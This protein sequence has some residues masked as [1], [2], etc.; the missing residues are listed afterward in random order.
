MNKTNAWKLAL[1]TAVAV[2]AT[3]VARADTIKIGVVAPFSGPFAIYGTQFKNAMDVWEAQHGKSVAGHKVEFIF[4]DSGGPNPSAARTATQE[5]LIKDRVNYLAGYVFT[6]NALAI[7][8]LINQSHTPTVI[9]NAAT[10]VINAKS[11]YFLRTSMTLPQVSAPLADW[12][13]ANGIKT[14]VTAVTDYGPGIDAQKAFAKEFEAKGGKILD[15]IR[16]PIKTTDFG[17]FIQ[18][19]K[20]DKPN[21]IFSFIPAGP[22]AFS[23]V[24][25]YTD[26][27]LKADGIKLIGTGDIDDETTLQ[28]L[29][30]ASIGIITSQHYSQA[31]P[32][33]MNQEF[34]AELKKLHPDAVANFASVGA[35]DG[36]HVLYRMIEAGGKDGAKGMKAVIGSSW[37]SPRGPL[38]L[39]PKTRTVTQNMYIREI[40]KGPD[41]KLENKEIETIKNVP[42]VGYPTK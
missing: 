7:A 33:K 32:S 1:A 22:P 2:G 4:K 5:L 16:M 11:K 36:M 34:V 6:P 25:A 13:Y 37:E 3:Q 24:K 38:T 8:P 28:G 30:D 12:A 26:N 19:A 31:H 29:G 23:F 14:V 39:D 35:Y 41:G 10:S 40:T 27:G 17:P 15:D 20:T 18:R 21:A 42:D 9:W